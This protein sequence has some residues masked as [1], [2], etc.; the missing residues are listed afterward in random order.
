ML[1]GPPRSSARFTS[2]RLCA[3]VIVPAGAKYAGNLVIFDDVRKAVGAEQ[4]D[5]AAHQQVVLNFDVGLAGA[6]SE[7]IGKHM[8]EI[9]CAA[10][11][12]GVVRL[13]S[14]R[15]WASV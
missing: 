15:R 7:R 3:P 11:S 1:S 9:R 5:V 13:D 2:A 4:D 14:A 10:S 6:A 12:V 8:T